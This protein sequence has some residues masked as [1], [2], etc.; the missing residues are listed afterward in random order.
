LGGNF[1]QMDGGKDVRLYHV[2]E[3]SSVEKSLE[4]INNTVFTGIVV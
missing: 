1:P 4:E 2:D 3:R